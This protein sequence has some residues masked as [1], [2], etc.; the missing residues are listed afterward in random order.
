MILQILHFFNTCFQ[1]D[2]PVSDAGKGSRQRP[3]RVSQEEY[4]K[5]WER[6]FPKKQSTEGEKEDEQDS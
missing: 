3:R 5:N 4:K 2:S 6:A 1:K